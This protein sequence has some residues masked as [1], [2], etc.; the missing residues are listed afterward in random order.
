MDRFHVV[1]GAVGALEGWALWALER[2]QTKR[3]D[4]LSDRVAFL[5]GKLTGIPGF[6]YDVACPT[7]EAPSSEACRGTDLYAHASRYAAERAES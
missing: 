4:R 1:L 5:E 6:P 2:A 3:L 7:C